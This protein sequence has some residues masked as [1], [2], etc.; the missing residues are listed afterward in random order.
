MFASVDRILMQV[1]YRYLYHYS[2][3]IR[4]IWKPSF[5]Y[6]SHYV[7]VFSNLQW[8]H[9]MDRKDNTNDKIIIMFIY[10][11]TIVYEFK[12]DTCNNIPGNIQNFRRGC[13][14]TVVVLLGLIVC[15]ATAPTAIKRNLA[16]LVTAVTTGLELPT[17]LIE[18]LGEG[19]S[20]IQVV[21]NVQ[22][23][24]Q[25]NIQVSTHWFYMQ[26][27]NKIKRVKRWQKSKKQ[28]LCQQ[29]VKIV[30]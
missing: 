12:K 29:P 24:S 3:N 27:L 17:E 5:F 18:G 14:A 6:A 19:S 22:T 13:S 8:C 21:V 7:I 15:A 4:D 16:H 10:N 30:R 1:R 9:L 26:E 23:D 11:N 2:I 20:S 25:G 28:K